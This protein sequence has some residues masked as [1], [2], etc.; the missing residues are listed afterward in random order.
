MTI[1][2]VVITIFILHWSN[3]SLFDYN[4]IR[5]Y[6]WTIGEHNYEVMSWKLGCL[7]AISLGLLIQILQWV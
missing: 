3:S 6:S 2:A 4:K 7:V 5:G 1:F